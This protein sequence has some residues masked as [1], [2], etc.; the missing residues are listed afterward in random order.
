MKWISSQPATLY[1]AWQVDVYLN[2]FI[3]MGVNPSDIYVILVYKDFNSIP[4]EI[5]K[6]TEGYKDVNFFLC[7]DTRSCASYIPS[8]YFNG[9]KQ[10]FKEFPELESQ[11]IMFHDSDTILL[12]PWDANELLEGDTW[13]FSDTNSYISYDYIMQKGVDVYKG[14]LDIVGLDENIPIQN[15]N[16]SGG[17]QH[18]IKNSTYE[19]WNKVEQD[20]INLYKYFQDIEPF[21]YKRH[22]SD[23][24]IQKWTAGMWS[25]LWNGWLF[26]NEI[27][28]SDKM[29]FCWAD[30]PISKSTDS[31]FMH[32]AGILNSDSRLFFKGDYINQL[33]YGVNLDID[34]EKCSY[35]YWNWIK[36]TE[37][38]TTITN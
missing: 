12:K 15:R 36:D 34:D 6:L 7:E 24:P 23:Y 30:N 3:K 13:Y 37:Q 25:L 21:Y 22:E 4:K 9:V 28:I 14:M 5:L 32:N 33:P 20:S 18:L 8:I 1:Y 31:Q 29:S 10:L 35:L 11:S 27:K 16:H 38:N 19:F 2:N 26:E 17:A